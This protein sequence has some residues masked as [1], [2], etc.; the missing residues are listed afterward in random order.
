MS[1]PTAPSP[2]Q[3]PLSSTIALTLEQIIGGEKNIPTLVRLF[4]SLPDHQ[5]ARECKKQ[6]IDPHIEEIE[7]KTGSKYDALFLAY[8]IQRW[9]QK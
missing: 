9:L 5:F 1:E 6:L 8:V 2:S 3:Q 7:R 4:T